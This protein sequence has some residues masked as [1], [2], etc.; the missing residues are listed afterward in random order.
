MFNSH[1]SNEDE[2]ADTIEQFQVAGTFH[3]VLF[4][5][6]NCKNNPLKRLAFSK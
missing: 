3:I 5:P 1:N 2:K 4:Q 6:P